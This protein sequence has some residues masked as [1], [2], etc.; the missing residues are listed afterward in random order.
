[1]YLKYLLTLETA[2][3]EQF[4]CQFQCDLA[5]RYDVFKQRME[6]S[7]AMFPDASVW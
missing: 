6:T 4:L 7:N 5:R 3:A 2:D 1:M